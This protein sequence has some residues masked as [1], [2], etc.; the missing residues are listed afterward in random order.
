MYKHM[1]FRH[2]DAIKKYVNSACLEESDL[3]ND[4]EK[5][6]LGEK[7]S[8]KNGLGKVDLEKRF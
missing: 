8:W 7:R 4:F 3:E 6:V 5:Q 1:F 2:A